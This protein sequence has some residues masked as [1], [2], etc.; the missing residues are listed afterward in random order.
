MEVTYRAAQKGDEKQLLELVGEV[1]SGYGLGLSIEEADLDIT[2]LKKF[3][4]DNNGWFE[5]VLYED[6]I[7]GSV[8]IYRIDTTTCELRKMYLYKEFQGVGIG[9]QLMDDALEVARALEYQTITLQTNSVLFKAIP[10]YKKYGFVDWESD[11]VCSRCD[12]AMIKNLRE[13]IR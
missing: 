9:K 3:Y 10:L 8:G 13:E 1:L 11:E 2:D 7:V 5:V 12:I 4:F 6:K